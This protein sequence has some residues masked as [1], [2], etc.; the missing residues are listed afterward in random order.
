MLQ[1]PWLFDVIA[2][3]EIRIGYATPRHATPLYANLRYATLRYAM[4]YVQ[5]ANY[6]P[7]TTKNI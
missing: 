4:L 7:A 2:N 1:A 3:I 5:S 6:E